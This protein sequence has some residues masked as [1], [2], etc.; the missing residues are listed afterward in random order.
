ME[1]ATQVVS[2]LEDD[3]ETDGE[4]EADDT[5]INAHPVAYMRVLAHSELEQIDFPID[6][7]MKTITIINYETLYM[8]CVLCVNVT[9]ETILGRGSE[10]NLVIPAKSL[11]RTHATILVEDGT[12]FVQDLGSR[13]KTYRGT[14]S[15]FPSVSYC[16]MICIR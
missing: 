5:L 11:S 10:S 7:G 13:N 4:E 15:P 12:H 16:I 3:D 8:L 1:E 6:N 14:V 2:H 9:G